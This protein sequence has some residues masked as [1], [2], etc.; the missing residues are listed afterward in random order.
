MAGPRASTFHGEVE[1]GGKWRSL[2]VTIVCAPA[3]TA[4]ARTCR[5]F[6]ALV[7][8]RTSCPNPVTQESGKWRR[9]SRSRYAVLLGSRPICSSNARFISMMISPDRTGRYRLGGS[10]KRNSASRSG[11][12]DENAGV[13]N[14]DSLTRHPLLSLFCPFRKDHLVI[15]ARFQFHAGHSVDGAVAFFVAAL[16]VYEQVCQVDAAVR[17]DHVEWQFAFLQQPHHEWAGNSE[18]I[19]GPLRRQLLVLWNDGYRFAGLHV[20]EDFVEEADDRT[21]QFGPATLGTNELDRAFQDQ[22]AQGADLRALFARNPD[23]RVSDGVHISS[24]PPVSHKRNKRFPR[25]NQSRRTGPARMAPQSP[26]KPDT[27]IR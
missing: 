27:T 15:R 6:S 24:R 3:C 23:W 13:E 25:N 1:A 18:K 14:R 4:A 11:R 9:S 20:L 2:K 19:R 26:A 21:G 7:I 10:A 12:W 5:S 22:L 16:L 8:L 17:A